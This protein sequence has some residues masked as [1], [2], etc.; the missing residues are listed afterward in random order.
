MKRDVGGIMRD[1]EA[2]QAAW[3]AKWK[4]L[5]Q[6][7]AAGREQD[8]VRTFCRL[9]LESDETGDRWEKAAAI[10]DAR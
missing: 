5:Y 3:L 2:E 7:T 6:A 8:I 4:A 9:E 10:L 1:L